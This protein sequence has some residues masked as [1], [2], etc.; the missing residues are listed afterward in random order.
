M[1]VPATMVAMRIVGWGAAT[2][3]VLCGLG[4]AGA[5]TAP[6]A[7]APEP[8]PAPAAP[9]WQDGLDIAPVESVDL[10]FDRPLLHTV[11]ARGYRLADDGAR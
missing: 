10:P 7:P 5:Q 4:D 2:F 8:A 3:A 9:D 1:T 6:T 11:S